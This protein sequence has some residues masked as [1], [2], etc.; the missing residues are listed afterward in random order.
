MR[1]PVT[2]GAAGSPVKGRKLS[3]ALLTF[4]VVLLGWTI[5]VFGQQRFPP[6]DF[7]SGYKLPLTA[8]PAARSLYLQYLDVAVLMG[9]VGL[10][11]YFVLKERSRK[12]VVGLSLFSFL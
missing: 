1:L 5:S 6:P 9:A 2:T 8:V 11:A 12:A 3:L 10:G 4:I 7:E